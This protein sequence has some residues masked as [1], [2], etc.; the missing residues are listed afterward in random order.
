MLEEEVIRSSGGG[1]RRWRGMNDYWSNLGF[2]IKIKKF[3]FHQSRDLV[4][5]GLRLRQET[6]ID[7]DKKVE[8]VEEVEQKEQEETDGDKNDNLEKVVGWIGPD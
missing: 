7:L 8:E 5:F 2:L 1:G 6:R 3:P 4:T